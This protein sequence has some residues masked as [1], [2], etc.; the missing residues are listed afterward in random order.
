MASLFTQHVRAIASGAIVYP[1]DEFMVALRKLLWSRMGRRGL[2]SAPPAYLGFSQY[3]SWS[4]EAALDDLTDVCYEHAVW[5]KRF[6]LRDHLRTK[7]NIDGLIHLNVDRFLTK[8]QERYDPVGFAAFQNLEAAVRMALEA[9]SLTAQ[10]LRKGHV[11]NETE[12]TLDTRRS[13]GREATQAE[14]RDALHSLH[15]WSQILRLLVRRSVEAQQH[16]RECFAQLAELGVRRVRF[17]DLAG[18]LKSEAREY[19]SHLHAVPASELDWEEHAHG[20]ALVRLIQP[21]DTAETRDAYLSLIACVERGID[22]IK[23]RRVR[24]RVRAILRELLDP[25]SLDSDDGVSQAELSRRLGVS[26]S[27]L[28]DS[29]RV[30][31]EIVQE[32]CSENPDTQTLG[33]LVVP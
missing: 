2:R 5:R 32:C 12:L 30:L 18:V 17:G 16:L 28:N 26:T 8:R 1:D 33:R 22:R 21:S 6:G 15:N 10:G 14:I 19:W 11:R 24:D 3:Q 31:R 4:D 13:A 7:A 29:F 20:Q 25:A 27:T 9:E 23:Q